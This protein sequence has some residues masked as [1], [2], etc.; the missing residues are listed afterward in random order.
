MSR[1]QDGNLSIHHRI[2]A[3][4]RLIATDEQSGLLTHIA[5]TEKRFIMRADEKP[6]VN[7]RSGVQAKVAA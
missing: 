1:P 5:V 6:L 2:S 4:Q 3:S 7:I